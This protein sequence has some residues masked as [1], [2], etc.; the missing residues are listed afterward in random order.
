MVGVQSIHIDGFRNVHNTKL[1]FNN[2]ITVLLAPNNYGKTNVLYA[3]GFAAS[4]IGKSG[5]AQRLQILKNQYTSNNLTR[6]GERAVESGFTFEINFLNRSKGDE[7]KTFI[8]SFSISPQL[9]VL[10]ENLSVNGE[11]IIRRERPD[12]VFFKEQAFG[13][14][15]HVLVASSAM[16]PGKDTNRYASVV[17]DTF[18][19]LADMP[20]NYENPYG[21]IQDMLL[22]ED[23]TPLERLILL[24][25]K[26]AARANDFKRA[27]LDLFPGILDFWIIDLTTG[28]EMKFEGFPKETAK[29]NYRLEFSSEGKKTPERLANLSSGTQNIFS[30][31]LNVYSKTRKTKPLIALEEIENGIHPSL[32][33]SVLKRLDSACD[34]ARALVTTHSPAVVRHMG[35]THLSAFYV[36]VPN[37]D[38]HAIF[39]P[40]NDRKK[41]EILRETQRHGLSIGE[42]IFELSSAT[43]ESYNKLKGWLDV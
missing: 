6:L 5:S 3:I 25:K 27:F 43:E 9:G 18:V 39:A 22:E 4:L 1:K 14:Q 26:S 40:L 31:L 38:G 2:P 33:R 35:E 34:P 7:E 42:L 36:G 32:H 16:L 28:S 23:S 17:R 19:N 10:T 20:C 21:E 41:D 37:H 29:E 12:K 24:C 13:V 15:S 11:T 8:Y 30:L